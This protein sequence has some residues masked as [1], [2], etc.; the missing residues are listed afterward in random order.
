[1]ITSSSNPRLKEIVKLRDGKHRRRSGLFLIDGRRELDRAIQCGVVIGD[2]FVTDELR[3]RELRERGLT[4]VLVAENVFPKITFGDRNDGLVAVAQAPEA[5]LASFSQRISND[6]PP[7]LAVLE[8]I[9]KPGNIGAVFRSADGAGFDGVIVADPLC[10]LLNP[11]AVRSSMGTIFRIPAA[12]AE[13][14][15]VIDWLRNNN[16]RLAV[17]RCDGAIPYNEYDFR[18]PTAIVL[19]SEAEGLSSTW[20]ESD[21]IPISLPMLGIADSLNVSNAAAVLFYEARRQR[22]ACS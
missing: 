21:M 5:T 14:R 10:D 13:S 9:E 8:G 6:P 1:M 17:A 12:V 18:Q 4:T 11:N 15:D 3:E 19:G 7:L 22:S 16:I 2:V 20:L